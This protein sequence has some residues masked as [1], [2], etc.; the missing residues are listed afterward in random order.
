MASLISIGLSGLNAS[1]AALST[2]GHNIANADTA[3]Y[4]R[5]QTIQVTAPATLNGLNY[6]GSGTTLDQ[7]RRVYNDYLNTQV[8]T[9]TSLNSESQT[10]LTQISQIDSLLSDSSTGLTTQLS[11][12][13][14]NLQTLSNSPADVSSRDLLLSSAQGLTNRFN[15][16]AAQLN[17]QTTYVN[18]QLV[19]LADRV[20]TLSSSIA[21]YNQSIMQ[22]SAN[23]TTP[24][25]LLDA[26]DEAV[27]QLA[28][29]VSVSVSKQ[30]GGYSVYMGS[31]Q[32]L[33]VGNRSSTLEAVPGSTDD[34]YRLQLTVGGGTTI[35]VTDVTS[36]GEIGGLLRYRSDVL[37]PTKA[38]LGRM[39]LA[40]SDQF[41]TQLAQGIDLNG[42]FG[43]A[44]FSDINSSNLMSQR[45]VASTTNDPTSGNLSV[46]IDSTSALT[47]SDYEVR[48]TSAT[49]FTVRQLPDGTEVT[50]QLPAGLSIDGM[51]IG[52]DASY[53]FAAGD[54]FT[55]NPTT[56]AASAMA[57]TLTDSSALGLAAPL[58]AA[59]TSGNVGTGQIG[60]PSVVST[61][62]S[63]SQAAL[64]AAAPIKLVFTDASN[65]NLYDRDGN[66]LASDTIIPGQSNTLKFDAGAPNTFTVEVPFSGTPV[67]GDSFSLN[68]TAANSSDNRNALEMLDL[69]TAKTIGGTVSFN[70]SYSQLVSGVGAKTSQAR[71]DATATDAVLTQANT[72]RESLSGV[73]LEE[74]A[75][76]L[77]KFEQYYNASAQ[78]IQ[79]AQTIFN[80]LINSF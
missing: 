57:V 73:N 25:D 51:F 10:Y 49:D 3:G 66:A 37:E 22:L 14:S 62:D 36:G 20:N 28:E 44:L 65:Y 26:R 23:G 7:V 33:V 48:F 11:G 40:I 15:T 61:L 41:N 75:A 2:T 80:T 42:N 30:D 63:N 19:T 68:L 1:Q 12:L 67:A 46:R 34:D 21:G 56:G 5:Q 54:S 69:Q 52:A 6:I 29:L 24:N 17:D 16:M 71:L 43:S 39:A 59:A 78:I 38:E 45:S 77:I 60:D 31:G 35:D 58:N 76:N 4:T 13:F 9:T 8:R 64:Q 27:R 53:T 79:T 47:T 55:L 32:P 18:D 72:A 74:E 50:G 70:G